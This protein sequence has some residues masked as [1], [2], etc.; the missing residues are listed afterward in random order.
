MHWLGMLGMPR[1]VYTYP[2]GLGWELPN[3]A[4]SIGSWI[5]G[6]SVLLFVFNVA[7]TLRSGQ[8]AGDNP[9]GASDLAWA[10]TSP[11]RPYNFVA[12]PVVESATPLWPLDRP[13]PVL[14]GLASHKREALLTTTAEAVPA[15]RWA[16]PDSG[17]WPLV[18]AIALTGLFIGSIFTPW[19]VVWGS[20]PFGIACTVWFWPKRS[21]PSLQVSP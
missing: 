4:A 13:L 12:A 3:L 8:R 1:R 10:A 6:A 7:R 20:I 15:T 9:W 11:P 5:V 18:A 19:A 17:I 21:Q 14:A 2:A 16:M